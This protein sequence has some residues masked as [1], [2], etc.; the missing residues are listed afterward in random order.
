MKHFIAIFTLGMLLNG[1]VDAQET[2]T[3]V[4]SGNMS[5]LFQSYQE[6]SIIGAVVPPSKSGFNAYS[7][8][9]YTQGNF[10]AGFRYES[11]LNSVLGFPGRFKG[12]GIGYRYARW[13][14]PE[15]GVD[16]TVGNFYETFGAGVLLR[17]YEE[18][19]LGLD[20]AMDGVRLLLSPIDGINVKMVYGKQVR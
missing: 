3:G 12:S 13:S 6:D 4:V 2:S 19:N 15:I 9:I 20:N 5:V 18:R 17:S 11:Y 7:N 10:S 14:D 1:I 16:V 8:L